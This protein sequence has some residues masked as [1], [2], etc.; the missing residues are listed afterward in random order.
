MVTL[1][2]NGITKPEDTAGKS[3]WYRN[4]PADIELAQRHFPRAMLIHTDSD[5]AIWEAIFQGKADAGQLAASAARAASFRQLAEVHRGALNFFPLAD[6]V[7]QMGIG[8]SFLRPEARRA[9]DALREEIGKM[10]QDGTLS[11]IYYRWFLDPNNESVSVFHLAA[12]RQQNLAMTVIIGVLL[13][14]LVML[15]WLGVHLRSEVTERRRISA[16]LENSKH[17]VDS[18]IKSMV[19]TLLVVQEDTTITFANPSALKLLGYPEAELVGRPLREVLKPIGAQNASPLDELKS[20]DVLIEREVNYRTK[21]GTLVPMTF[22]ASALRTGERTAFVCVAQDISERKQAERKL[23]TVQ[24]QLQVSSRRAGMAEVATN[25]LHNVGNV[26]NSVNVTATLVDQRMRESKTANVAR[27]AALLRENQTDLAAFLTS[28]ARGQQLPIYLETLGEHLANEQKE[29]LQE[30]D[31]LRKN[32]DHIK[33]VVAMQQS[34]GQVL[35]MTAPLPLVDLVE[36]ALRINASAFSRHDISLVRDYLV[37]PVVLVDK[38]KVLQILVNL[39]VN[40]KHAVDELGRPDKQITVRISGDD[41]HARVSVIDNGVGIP[42]ENLTR[43]F[44]HGFTTRVSGHGFGLHS[45]ALAA[46]ELGG[47]LAAQ[48]EGPGRG[49]TFV[50]ELPLG[51]RRDVE[52]GRALPLSA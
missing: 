9:A 6:G 42:A 26:L 4:G 1:K 21:S 16:A 31:S 22:S 18:I 34:Y 35:G 28:D 7:L 19:N 30:L 10:A 36:D 15:A 23:E 25:V 47:S 46:Q 40:A 44:A 50:L 24:Q 27:V 49:A 38:H 3:V 48:S 52:Q 8:A 12:V 2:S 20:R 5:N 51:Q 33:D 39:L 11:S 43:I 32:I 14:V 41:E 45:G 29:V 13:A 37:H 17:Y